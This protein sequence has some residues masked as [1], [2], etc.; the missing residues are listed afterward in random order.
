MPTPAGSWNGRAPGTHAYSICPGTPSHSKPPAG[1]PAVPAP[2]GSREMITWC[3]SFGVPGM[4]SA[5]TRSVATV[6]PGSS[7]KHQYTSSGPAAPG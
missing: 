7:A 2:P 5:A 1:L 3:T 4:I 6:T